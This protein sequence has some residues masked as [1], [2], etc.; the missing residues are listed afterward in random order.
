MRNEH[1]NT[2]A[3]FQLVFG[4]NMKRELPYN[5]KYFHDFYKLDN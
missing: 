1:Q 4:E 3:P 5:N 2:P